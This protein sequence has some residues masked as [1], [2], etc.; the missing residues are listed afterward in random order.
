MKL[1]YDD[2]G[3]T[4]VIILDKSGGRTLVDIV[5]A[6]QTGKALNKRTNAFKLA[7]RI[8]DEL[9]VF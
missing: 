5:G 1:C 3:D 2:K 4:I 9:P 8:D 7:R 6:A